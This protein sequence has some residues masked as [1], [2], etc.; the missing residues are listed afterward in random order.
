MKIYYGDILVG[1]VLT[2]RSLTVNEALE[3]VGFDEQE[4][5]AKHGFDDID[6][7]DFRLDYSGN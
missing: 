4:F 2:N 7:N 5:V 3:Q 1:H 6:Y